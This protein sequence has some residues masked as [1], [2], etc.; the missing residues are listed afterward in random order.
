[1]SYE[2]FSVEDILEKIGMNEV[3]L[4]AIQRKFVWDHDQIESLFDSIMRGYPIGTFLFWFVRG[5]HRN[6]Y[7]FYKFIQ[8][9]HERDSY[10]NET[11][12]NPHLRR[13]IIGVLDGQ[14][15][16]SSLF[17]ALQ[18]TYAYRRRYARKHSPTAYP[19]RKLYL[20][21]L[22][23][24]GTGQDEELHFDFRFLDDDEASKV[25][26]EQLW[27]LARDVLRWGRDPDDD[28]YYDQVLEESGHSPELAAAIRGKRKTIKKNLR[29]LHQRLVR[30]EI[31]SYFRVKEQDLDKLLDIFVRVNS[32]GTVLKKSDLLFSTIVANWEDARPEIEN[33]L[34]TINRKGEGFGFD[35]DFIMRSCLVLTDSPVLFKVKGFRKKNIVRIKAEWDR[36]KGALVKTVDLLVSFGFNEEN[37]KSNNAV[38]PIAYYIMKGGKLNSRV[39]KELQKYLIHS[40]LKRVYGRQGDQVLSKIRDSLRKKDGDDYK[41]KQGAFNF[42]DLAGTKLPGSASLKL[43]QEDLQDILESRKGPY[44]FMVLSLLYPNLRFGQVKFHQ[45]HIHPASQFD[46]KKLKS[47]SIPKETRRTWQ[48]R[49]DELPNL[50]LM[51]GTENKSKNRTPFR[52]W[53]YGKGDSSKRQVADPS[54]FLRDNYIP[55][56]VSLEPVQFEDFFERR[57]QLLRDQIMRKL[58]V[59]EQESA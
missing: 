5:K 47:L 56:N 14:Q 44:T 38:I 31:I 42:D 8:E 20:N 30:D 9:Y 54:K 53:L 15:R 55:A 45:D 43:T 46:E 59:V 28:E 40:L 33:L 7:T 32:G 35:N 1:M 27:F 21:L 4:P 16:L 51:E 11:A 57:K 34:E 12:S 49:K 6:N 2:T 23:D 3:Y 58:I 52:D 29:I 18:G 22:K 50:Q 37:L 26:E 36:I 10:L 17:L 19:K 48:R 13:E 39:K 24:G 25:D 41:L